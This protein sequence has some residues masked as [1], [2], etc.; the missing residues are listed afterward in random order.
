MLRIGDKRCFVHVPQGAP[1]EDP[2]GDDLPYYD[3]CQN[4][5]TVDCLCGGDM[6]VCGDEEIPG[7]IS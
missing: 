4:M 7:L 6:C 3:R 1:D 5:G 2:Y